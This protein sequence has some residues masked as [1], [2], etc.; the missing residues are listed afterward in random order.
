[1]NTYTWDF[2]KFNAH[3]NLNG[4]EKVIFNIEFILNGSDGEGHGAQVFGTVGLGE[5]GDDFVP[6]EQLTPEQVVTMV[7]TALGDDLAEYKNMLD[8]KIQEQLTPTVLELGTPWVVTATNNT[9][10]G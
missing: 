8:S 5:P 10:V 7:E 9:I 4:R 6:F 1:M 2:L 3:S